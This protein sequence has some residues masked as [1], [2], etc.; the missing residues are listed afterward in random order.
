M[1]VKKKSIWGVAITAI[2]L[3]ILLRFV[4]W[5]EIWETL[6]KLPFEALVVAFIVYFLVYFFR[7]W[8]YYTLNL[9]NVKLSRM[10]SIV[11]LYNMVNVF[12]PFKTGEIGYAYLLDK[13]GITYSQGIATLII[14]R[15]FDVFSILSI[16]FIAYL[17]FDSPSARVGSFLLTFFIV[18][19][20][21]IV[22]VILLVIH[23]NRFG[24]FAKK[25]WKFFHIEDSKILFYSFR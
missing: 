15:L 16:F 20:V 18:V 17:F 7:T 8:R 11:G 25:V 12:L 13:D 4:S 19:F 23:K 9:K 14:A 22:S 1:K 6:Q 24:V 10:F 5:A 3:F 21:L 2:L